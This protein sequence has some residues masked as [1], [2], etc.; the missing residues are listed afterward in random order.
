MAKLNKQEQLLRDNILKQRGVSFEPNTRNIISPYDAKT[1]FKKTTK[2]RLLELKLHKPIQEIICTGDS[3]YDL[4]AKLNKLIAPEKIDV[5]TI[6]KWRVIIN[7]TFWS[8][9]KDPPKE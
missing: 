7:E 6:S 1:K 5:T 2:M 8:D 3:I 4:E 9:F